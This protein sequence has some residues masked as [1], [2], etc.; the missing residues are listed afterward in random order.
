MIYPK[1]YGPPYVQNAQPCMQCLPVRSV[2]SQGHE[3]AAN[4]TGNG[5]GHDPGEEEEADTL[6]VDGL[7]GAVAEADADGRARDAHG[8]RHGQRVLREDQDGDGGPQFH[9]RA[10]ARRVVGELVAH[11]C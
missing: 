7:E 9:G 8:R 4:E 10:A 3:A 11:D 5:D 6:P 2:N 1:F